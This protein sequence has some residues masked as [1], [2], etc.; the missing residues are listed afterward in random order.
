M[1]KYVCMILCKEMVPT[2]G[3]LLSSLVKKN[4]NEFTVLVRGFILQIYGIIM[5][6][7]IKDENSYITLVLLN[8]VLLKCASYSQ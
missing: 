3:K 4:R 2:T 7:Q 8:S 1:N 5:D 6:K